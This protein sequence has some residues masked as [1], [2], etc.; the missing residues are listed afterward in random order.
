MQIMNGLL[1]KFSPNAKNLCVI[2]SGCF[3]GF[4]VFKQEKFEFIFDLMDGFISYFGIMS[5]VSF[6]I[7]AVLM[8]RFDRKSL[9]TQYASE[10][11]REAINIAGEMNVEVWR[12]VFMLLPVL[13]YFM[14]SFFNEHNRFGASLLAAI[15]FIAIVFSIFLP[16][17]YVDF[18][19]LQ[20]INVVVK[21]EDDEAKKYEGSANALLKEININ[22]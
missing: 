3:I 9:E 1:N 17:K 8:Q 15:T 12:I 16:F 6:A 19:R 20:L 14:M 22:R 21:K 4:F 13:A 18:I 5:S 7:L 2:V 10:I 11:K